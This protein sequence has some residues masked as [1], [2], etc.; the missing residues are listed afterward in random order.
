MLNRLKRILSRKSSEEARDSAGPPEGSGILV[1]AYC[2]R[3]VVP[4]LTFPHR[5]NVKRGRADAELDEH[6]NGFVGYVA[7]RGDRKSVV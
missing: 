5:L 3:R 2:T 6:L 1:N 7:S 4:E